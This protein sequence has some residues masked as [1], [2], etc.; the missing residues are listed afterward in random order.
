MIRSSRSISVADVAGHYD[1]LDRFY[2]DVWGRHVHHGLWASGRE[3]PEEAVQELVRLI[4][5]KA[6]IGVGDTVCD[7]GCGY[8][9][10][11]LQLA[12]EYGSDVVG[13]TVS[14][15]QLDFA[16]SQT[17]AGSSLRFLLRDWEV[18]GLDSMSFSAVVSIECL[19]HVDDKRKFFA[20]VFRVLRPGRKAAVAAWLSAPEPRGWHVRHLLEPICREGRLAGLGTEREYRQ[21]IEA[22]GLELV[23]FQSLRRQ[24]RR[25]WSICAR[26]VVAGVLTQPAYRQ[27]LFKRP[28][29]NWIFFVTLWR[30]ILAYRVK[31]MDYGL[32]IA[33]RPPLSESAEFRGT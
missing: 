12:T 26:R 1:D 13:L 3:D 9:A 29:S 11:A 25:T 33:R 7:V 14:P 18:N 27:F 32:F 20:E 6:E 10:T 22:A 4:A 23:E 15:A 24:V 8:G 17:R 5:E 21:M 28:T 19:A 2:R 31:A 30:I 16:T